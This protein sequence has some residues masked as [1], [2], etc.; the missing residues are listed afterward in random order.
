MTP[1]TLSS[2]TGFARSNGTLDALSWQWELRS[3]NGKGLDLRIRLPS[4]FE[5]L[6]IPVRQALSNVLRRGNIQVSLSMSGQV[7]ETVV[8]INDAVLDQ[9][10]E[11]ATVLRKKLR[12]PALQ[13]DTLMALRGVIEIEPKPVA[14][15]IQRK[16]DAALLK[17]LEKAIKD[18]DQMRKDEGR[19]INQVLGN[20]IDTIDELV[21]SAR[22]CPARAPEAIRQRLNE[23]VSKLLATSTQL[24]P[25]RLH[26]EALLLATRGDIQ[27]ELDRLFSHI[28]AARELLSSSDAVGRK[29]DFLAQEFNRES[30]T[31][32]SKSNDRQLTAIGLDLKTVVD[33]LREQV[34]NIE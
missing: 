33:Q 30:N 6:E 24:D 19:R 4:G 16:R 27:E 14:D 28:T 9:I 1:S 23:Q 10:L 31:L 11:R 22:D 29:L 5:H 8:T 25:D 13:A 2:M 15:V 34:Q 7:T 21:K 20:N 3:V 12:G 26:Q 18:L 32:C 17:S